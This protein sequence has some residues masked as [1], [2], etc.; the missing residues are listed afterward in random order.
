MR[1]SKSPPRF[2]SPLRAAAVV[3]ATVAVIAGA[4]VWAD[5]LLVEA[6]IALILGTVFP[7]L[8]LVAVVAPGPGASSL[9]ELVVRP[10][11]GSRRRTLALLAAAVFCATLMIGW[12][13]LDGF[14]SSSDEYAYVIQAQTYLTGRLWV[15][16]PSPIEAF[17]Q[18]RVIAKNGMWLSIYQPGWALLLTIPVALGLPAWLLNPVL[19]TLLV[20]AFYRLSRTSIG[21]EATW[22]SL[23]GLCTS[24]FFLF[25]YASYFSHGA[26]ALAAVLFAYC[27]VR[28]LK[29]GSWRWALLAGLSLGALGFIRAANAV[30]FAVPFVIA[31]LGSPGRRSGLAWF[32]LGGA[33]FAVALLLYQKV[34][35]G[36]ALMPVQYWLLNGSEPFG[37][38]S[39]YQGE[40]LRRALRLMLWTSPVIVV[41][42]PLALSWLGYRRR[43]SFV[44]WL[45]PLTVLGFVFYGGH[46]GVQ[47]G[48]RYYFECWPF[49]FFTM[50]KAFDALLAADPRKRNWLASAFLVHVAVQ[51][52]FLVPRA[53]REHAVIQETQLPYRR[54]REAHLRDAVVLLVDR[55]GS[56]KPV[57]PRDLVRNGL[58]VGDEPVTFALDKDPAATRA[59]RELFP[60]RRFY[61]YA[62]GQLRALTD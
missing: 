34:V 6:Q 7:L 13:A 62:D 47:Y 5:R 49:V 26:G 54:A 61:R 38:R 32:A 19:A 39:S 16:P 53:E 40:T 10:M 25:N 37:L 33:P 24:S 15:E 4:T 56:I 9:L 46:G 35:T 55:V 31:L 1:K 50:G 58:R 41:A 59:V 48:P 45:A 11:A 12:L 36:S 27:G 52:G 30:L 21:A 29:G 8:T 2:E 42:W 22:L 14:A 3:L 18:V 17:E 60:S 23:L 28:Y 20:A 44:D 43:L 51:L 57:D